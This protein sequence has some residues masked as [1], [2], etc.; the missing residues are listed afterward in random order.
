MG[1]KEIPQFTKI[2]ADSDFDGLIGA[3]ILKAYNPAAEVKFSHAALVRNGNMDEEINASTVIVD[4]PFHQ[5]CGWYLDHHQ[6]NKPTK[7]ESLDFEKKGG[8]TDWQATPSAARLV[9]DLIHSHCDLA[10]F[11]EVMPFVDALDSGGITIEQ[12]REDGELM[13]FSR[14]LK[15]TESDYMN[16]IV[17]H[18]SQGKTIFQILQ[19]PEVKSRLLVQQE[20]RLA[21]EHVVQANT[22]IINRLAVCHLQD[23]GYFSNGYL[24]TAWAGDKADACCIIHGFTDGDINDAKRPPLS[25]SFYANSFIQGG[26]GKYDLSRLATKFDPS[27]G[28]HMN[29]CGCRIQPPGLD[30][31]LAKWLHMWAERDTVLAV[32]HNTANM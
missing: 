9:Y 7:Q 1:A 25:A 17:T 32:N 11:V 29:A 28:G 27:G 10:N 31:N 22:V 2:V 15:V 5:N 6:T 26:Q 20:Q 16:D 13:R 4:L 19:L 23:T 3:A 24:V 8:V 21:I 30:D 12:F 18:L 14:T